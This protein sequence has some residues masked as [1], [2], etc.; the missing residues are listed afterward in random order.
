[1]LSPTLQRAQKQITELGV[2][3]VGQMREKYENRNSRLIEQ[4]KKYISENIEDPELDL[5]GVSENIGL[6]KAYFCSLFKRE[7]GYGFTEYVNHQR[8]E[9]AKVLL[10]TTNLRV[11]E[12]AEAV[13]YV[14]PKYFFQVFKRIT[15]KRPKDFYNSSLFL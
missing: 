14:S 4:A 3:L 11:Y 12:V 2:A 5:F 8:I 10:S 1:M 9:K 7:T 6:S 13:G 15:N